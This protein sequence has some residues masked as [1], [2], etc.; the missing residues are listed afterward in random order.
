M[1]YGYV[2][3]TII[4]DNDIKKVEPRKEPDLSKWITGSAEVKK[5]PADKNRNITPP[6]Y[7]CFYENRW[8]PLELFNEQWYWLDW[9]SNLKLLGYWVKKK[10]AIDRGYYSLGHPDMEPPTPTQTQLEEST[11][12]RQCAESASVNYQISFCML[13]NIVQHCATLGN[14]KNLLTRIYVILAETYFEKN[15]VTNLNKY[16]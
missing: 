8:F 11:R 15:V 5:P 6:S 7:H 1:E 9:D 2:M 13:H 4:C 10:D 3:R 14:Y 12:A 16:V